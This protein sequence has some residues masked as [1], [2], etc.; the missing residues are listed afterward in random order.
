MSQNFTLSTLKLGGMQ[1]ING[2]HLKVTLNC[3]EKSPG[4][5][6]INWE[7]FL[8]TT[9]EQTGNSAAAELFLKINAIQGSSSA[10]SIEAIPWLPND[11]WYNFY[12]PSYSKK[13]ESGSFDYYHDSNGKA[14]FNITLDANIGGVQDDAY[15]NFLDTTTKITLTDSMPYTNCGA[16]T[17][18][19]AS[20]IIKPNGTF[21]V[22][23]SGATA[24]TS[25]PIKRYEVYYLLSSNGAA[26][27][28]SN[29]TGMALIESTSSS[30][31]TTFTVSGA[32]RGHKI[33]CGVI[34]KGAQYNSNNPI[35]TGGS[36]TINSLPGAPTVSVNKT[37]VPST[38]GQVTFTVTAGTDNNSSQTKT[39]YYSTSSSPSSTKTKITSP[40]SPTVTATT[41]YYFWTY[42]GLEYS[43]SPS[44]GIKITKN[45]KPKFSA[46][47]SSQN[48]ISENKPSGENYTISPTITLTVDTTVGQPNRKFTYILEYGP[49]ASL[50]SSKTIYTNITDTQIQ[51][52]DIR[53]Q[54]IGHEASGAY[55]RFS[56]QCYDGIEY[57]AVVPT[58]T[59]YVTKVPS[60]ESLYNK[61][62][63]SSVFGFYNGNIATHY[64]KYLNFVFAKDQ[65]YNI[66][67]FNNQ[68]GN[69]QTISLTTG[70]KTAGSWTT[71]EEID[72]S[73]THN[74]SYR[75]GYT[76][77]YINKTTTDQS[78][79]K[80]ARTIL[81]NFNFALN[82][83][84]YSF[85]TDSAIYSNT[86]GHNYNNSP[87][88]EG[89]IK[90]Y[91]INSKLDSNHVFV[92]INTNNSWTSSIGVSPKSATSDNTIE[93]MLPM[94]SVAE[95][96]AK[97]FTSTQ[98]N[99]LYD[100]TI[101]FYVKNDFGDE[102]SISSQFRINFIENDNISLEKQQIYP[103]T[104][105]ETN[106]IDTWLYLKEGMGDLIGNFIIKSYNT[107]P[108]GEIQ[109]LRSTETNWQTLVSFNFSGSGNAAPSSPIS[110]SISNLTVQT[111]GEISNSNYTISYR[112]K[113]ITDAG[114]KTFQLYNNI[115]VCG[116]IPA[117]LSIEGSQYN[118][119]NKVL[120]LKYK[121]ISA[122]ADV[123]NLELGNENKITL[124]L[125]GTQTP[126][127]E[128]DI[129]S[130]SDYF[131]NLD[132][133]KTATFEYD[134]GASESNLV[135]LGITTT[136]S[137]YLKTDTSTPYF[138]TTK[139]PNLDIITPAT[140]FN[141][142]PTIA[143]RKNHLGINI[144]EPSNNDNAIIVI[145][146]A[147]G[148][149][150]IYFQSAS[151]NYGKVQNFIVDCGSW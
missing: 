20:G 16:P 130:P 64:S 129:S 74:L 75:L 90:E 101:Y 140:V 62:A 147:S 119:G 116:H 95:E 109:I 125:N 18:V 81:K 34:T 60:L 92:K 115:P 51:I 141:I 24:G 22:S 98:K 87:L 85:F 38:N 42:D 79:T 65:G 44:T 126:I 113:V 28:A 144:L 49:S 57:S 136:L 36:V 111:I 122:G 104:S 58:H 30:G 70:T 37:I 6:T 73:I 102:T 88:T 48:L 128:S 25:N 69:E 91:G 47:I 41:T 8:G 137:T 45:T 127:S 84:N 4:V 29:Y 71:N 83:Q 93:F 82:N 139:T 17:S 21:T 54:N 112:L 53:T 120:E 7:S 124:F 19:K 55:Y 151:G 14:S 40:W 10:T 100:A 43:S 5:T 145:G 56:I 143:Y 134:F 148:R 66:L 15:N 133:L 96:I 46:S 31:S 61:D 131:S 114:S 9:G 107:G 89:K 12:D 86:V 50:G 146:E 72:S 13:V 39:L 27:S 77:G 106:T 26:P 132:S 76:S 105:T 135:K 123:S 142:L 150:T 2:F 3:V 67:K 32:T 138:Q 11:G 33:V 117:V 80:I 118:E 59:R 78:I 149:D 68:A 121:I 94:S 108:K 103:E 99:N 23:W 52:A 97:L 1:S 63:S 110:Y 35:K